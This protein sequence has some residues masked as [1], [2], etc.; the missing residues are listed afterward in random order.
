MG[1]DGDQEERGD[2]RHHRGARAE[3]EPVNIEFVASVLRN[4]GAAEEADVTRRIAKA[5]MEAREEVR[6]HDGDRY[7]A[8]RQKVD[9]FQIAS[10]IDLNHAWDAGDI[11]SS[12]E[13]LRSL[14]YK[15][16]SVQSGINACEDIKGMLE[17]VLTLAMLPDDAKKE[18]A[19]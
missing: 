19:A 9:E 7:K 14:R 1:L 13:T 15:V 2:A 18:K 16:Q 12:V 8:L 4:F 11:G 3:P 5:V 17:K 6:S 10:G